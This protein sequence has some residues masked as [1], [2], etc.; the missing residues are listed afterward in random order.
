MSKIVINPEKNL[1]TVGSRT[2]QVMGSETAKKGLKNEMHEHDYFVIFATF[3]KANNFCTHI[4]GEFTC[5]VTRVKVL[6]FSKSVL[7][8]DYA[9]DKL[10]PIN[11][12]LFTSLPIPMIFDTS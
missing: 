10:P 11:L 9:Y 3:H 4:I 5:V 1:D 7:K 6:L 2:E 8:K 12:P